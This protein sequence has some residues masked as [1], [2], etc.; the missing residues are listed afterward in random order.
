MLNK[1]ALLVSAALLAV[2]VAAT[3]HESYDAVSAS[4][5]VGNNHRPSRR[6]HRQSRGEHGRHSRAHERRHA[7]RHGHRHGHRPRSHRHWPD[8]HYYN[9]GPPAY[10]HG[11]RRRHRHSHYW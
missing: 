2:P 8:Y 6:S 4:T 7:P 1:V 9:Y 10:Y 11:P 3:A 5:E